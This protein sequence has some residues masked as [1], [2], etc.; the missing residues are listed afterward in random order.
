VIFP[1]LG[2]K[3]I[4]T[5]RCR[6]QISAGKKSGGRLA[7]G[8]FQKIPL[9]P[10]H[11]HR[12]HGVRAEHHRLHPRAPATLA[13]LPGQRTTSPR[14]APPAAWPP[15]AGSLLRGAGYPRPARAPA[16]ERSVL[17]G[18]KVHRT[19]R[20]RGGGVGVGAARARGLRRRL[21][22]AVPPHCARSGLG[23]R[24]IGYSASSFDRCS[25]M[26]DI[27]RSFILV[28]CQPR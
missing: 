18:G 4:H 20:V 5:C 17:R 10:A 25:L 24:G 11:R 8:T 21:V 3:K 7:I 22:W 12:P 26:H 9:L 16:R 14:H 28:L 19:E 1:E 15:R 2:Q 6:H 13:A 23:F 27:F